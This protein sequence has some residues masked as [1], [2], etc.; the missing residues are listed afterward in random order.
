VLPAGRFTYILN[1]QE[2][3]S[4]PELAPSRRLTNDAGELFFISNQQA[5]LPAI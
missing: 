4:F 5:F 3:E 2:A 1:C